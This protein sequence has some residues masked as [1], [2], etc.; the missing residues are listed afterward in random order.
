MSMDASGK[1]GG[2]LVFGKWKGRATVRQLVRPANPKSANQETA[3]N[4]IRVLGAGQH[5]ASMTALIV[6]AVGM[7]DVE[8][9]T[10][11]APAGQAWNGFLVKSAIGTG[12]L[13]YTAAAAAYAALTAPQKTA[14]NDA[15]IALVPAIPAVAQFD[16]LGVAIAPMS[17][18]EVFFHYSYGLYIAGVTDVPPGAVPPVYA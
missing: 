9:L 15:A 13:H 1:F 12:S 2:T 3:R 8:A 7:T 6:A 5:F 11:L 10:A 4:A 14:W 17:A 18:G 16:A